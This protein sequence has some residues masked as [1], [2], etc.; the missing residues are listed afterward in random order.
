MFK[1]LNEMLRISKLEKSLHSLFNRTKNG[2]NHGI[3]K[4]LY[5]TVYFHSREIIGTRVLFILKQQ[6]TKCYKKKL[7]M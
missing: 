6:I 5:M 4:I 3:S 2:P 7:G 1:N